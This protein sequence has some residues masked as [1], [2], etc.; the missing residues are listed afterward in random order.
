MNTEKQYIQ[1]F[2][3]GYTLAEYEPN[4]LNTISKNLSHSNMYLNGLLAGEQEH[5]LEKNK[6]ALAELSEL[7]NIAKDRNNDF[8]RED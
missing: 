6:E 8:K 2:N 1:A 4:L 3:N 5:E 7:R